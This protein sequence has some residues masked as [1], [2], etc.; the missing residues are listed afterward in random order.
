MNYHQP[1]PVSVWNGEHFYYPPYPQ[2][3]PHP[4]PST[5]TSGWYD[6]SHSYG[7]IPPP[8]IPPVPPSPDQSDE[9]NEYWKG[10]FAPFPGFS[11]RPGLLPV[12]QM[13][14]LSGPV[15]KIS[16]HNPPM[17]LLPPRSF[18]R[19]PEPGE[20]LEKEEGEPLVQKVRILTTFLYQSHLAHLVV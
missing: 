17:H 8:T 1:P 15:P 16:P 19:L 13:P 6:V 11:S 5:D 10:R 4:W 14:R 2:P 18:M 9:L 3:Q 7:Y 12:K 20:S